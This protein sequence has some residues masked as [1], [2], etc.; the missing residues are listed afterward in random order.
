M[1]YWRGYL[2]AA[3]FAAMTWGLAEFAKAHWELV[4]MVYPYVTRLIQNYLVEWNSGIGICLWQLLLMAAGVLLLASIVLMIIFKWNPIQWFGWVAAAAAIAVFLNTALV[5]LNDYAGPIAQDI[6]LN[7]TDYNLAELEA[8]GTFYRDKAN[9]LSQQVA[10]NPDGTVK[11]PEFQVLAQQAGDGF[12][13]QTYDRFNSVFAGSTAPVKEL[14]WDGL[15]AGRGITGI[16][17]GITGE[18][19]V[20]PQTPAVALPFVMCREMAKRMCITNPQDAAFAAFLACDANTAV[21]FQYAGYMMAYRYC[22][23]AVSGLDTP[24]AQGSALRLAQGESSHLKADLKV[25]NDSFAAQRNDNYVTEEDA[26]GAQRSHVVDLLVS[27][28]I[29]EYVLPQMEE[30]KVLFD[31]L[32]ETQVDLSGLPN[33]N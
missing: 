28:H 20:N 33:V 19:A 4:D 17:V 12:E 13:N 7:V 1:K 10:R 25:Y 15:F 27:W 11:Y 22:Y 18:A 26:T 21:E 6:R 24:T 30:E 5:G 14:G 9:E 31:P 16:T 8:A 3:I 29:Q 23:D 32:D 2:V